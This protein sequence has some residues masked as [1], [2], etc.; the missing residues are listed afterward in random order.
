[1]LIGTVFSI[2]ARRR[3][4]EKNDL[5]VFFILVSLYSY[6]EIYTT[7]C[8]VEGAESK[9][10]VYAAC[11]IGGQTQSKDVWTRIIH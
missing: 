7:C 5:R 2:H 4:R 6:E 8:D 1:M 3:M 10:V 11:H 9:S